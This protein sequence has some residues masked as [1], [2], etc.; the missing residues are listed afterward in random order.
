MCRLT[1]DD[2]RAS[3]STP[4]VLKTPCELDV[5]AA[6]DFLAGGWRAKFRVVVV[7]EIL[8][9]DGPFQRLRRLPAEPA[10]ELAVGRDRLVR[11]PTDV[12]KSEIELQMGPQVQGLTQEPQMIRIVRFG[13]AEGL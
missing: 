5:R 4:H 10:I 12:T 7:Q 2:A 11:N 13:A 3:A 9:D 8:P 1:S 6:F